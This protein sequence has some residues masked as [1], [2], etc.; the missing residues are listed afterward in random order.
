M[1]KSKAGRFNKKILS[2]VATISAFYL[3]NK[4]AINQNFKENNLIYVPVRIIAKNPHSLSDALG[5]I[6][7]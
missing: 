3:L 5:K 2:K 1:H 7:K 6:K 4:R